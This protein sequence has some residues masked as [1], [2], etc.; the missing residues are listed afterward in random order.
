MLNNMARRGEKVIAQPVEGEWLTTGD[1]LRFLQTTLKFAME[2][3]EIKKDLM[4]FIKN[5]II[6]E[7][8][9]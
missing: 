5:E 2:R 6:K 1:P 8:F 3:P 7:G 4:H 9:F